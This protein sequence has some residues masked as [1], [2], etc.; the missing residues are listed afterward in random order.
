MTTEE[1]RRSREDLARAAEA[2]STRV[3]ELSQHLRVS[4]KQVYRLKIV[5][6]VVVGL[7][8]LSLGGGG[9]S[10]YLYTQVRE[11]QKQNCINTNEARQGN[12]VLWKVILAANAAKQTP[13]Q[14]RQAVL[15]NTWID[16]LYAQHD[17]NDLNKK[18]TIPPPPNLG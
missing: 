2:L 1:A 13:A 18:Y 17:C 6:W 15:F 10:Y 4:Q 7:A 3:D 11:T 8:L 12:L 16:K 9:A 5:T 14:K